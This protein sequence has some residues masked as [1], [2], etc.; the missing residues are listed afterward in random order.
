M[1][2][3]VSTSYKCKME[4]KVFFTKVVKNAKKV[5][6]RAKKVLMK[7]KRVK[8][9]LNTSA[10][11]EKPYKKYEAGKIIFP[12]YDREPVT[13][14][15]RYIYDEKEKLYK[16]KKQ[17]GENKAVIMCAGDLMCEPAMSKAMMVNQ[18]YYFEQGFKQVKGVF[19]YSDFAVANLETT[20]S[21]NV[22][23]AHETH[24]IEGRYHCNAPIEYLDALK[25]AGFDALVQANNHNA[26]AGAD[27]L[28]DTVK[29]VENKGFMHTGL[30]TGENDKRYLI[31]DINGIKVAFLSYTE[32]INRGLD[33]KILNKLG[34]EVLVNRYSAEKLE[35]D[36]KEAKKDGAEF[37]MCYIHFN[38]KEYTHE[39]TEHQEKRAKEMADLGVDCIMGSHAH[40]LQRYDEIFLDTGKR[41]PVVYSLGNF[42]TSDN[43]S[44]ITRKSI[45]YMITLVKENGRVNIEKE[46]C[47]PCRLV[48][49]M[50]RSSFDIWPTSPCWT[51]NIERQLLLEA[52]QQIVEVMGPKL[53]VFRI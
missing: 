47:I 1:Y 53:P 8:A 22:P 36:I 18:K 9:V 11:V 35:K 37:I 46:G 6:R 34:Q 23:Y 30:F 10:H 29:N 39:V 26:D 33:K 21:A 52:E 14:G 44:M 12:I 2:F 28:I 50:G 20:V 13:Y 5:L 32:H 19:A 42:M 40:A 17:N 27:G 24:K 3:S 4:G 43:T 49:G 45:I 7:S 25:F 16:S 48:E 51:D 38:C 41:V 15:G 31:A